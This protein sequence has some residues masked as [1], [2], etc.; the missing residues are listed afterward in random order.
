MSRDRR[1]R[2]GFKHASSMDNMNL[3]MLSMLKT[4]QERLAVMERMSTINDNLGAYIEPEEEVPLYVQKEG[5]AWQKKVHGVRATRDLGMNWVERYSHKLDEMEIV[6]TIAGKR[7]AAPKTA[8]ERE[9]NKALRSAFMKKIVRKPDLPR[10]PS[11]MEDTDFVAFDKQANGNLRSQMCCKCWLAAGPGPK[12]LDC[13]YCGAFVHASCVGEV[14]DRRF[15]F[16]SDTEHEDGNFICP[17]CEDSMNA[18][19]KHRNRTYDRNIHKYRT[20]CAV[21]KMQAGIRAAT[22]GRWFQRAVKAAKYIQRVVRARQ[23][24]KQQ[25]IVKKTEKRPVRIRIH[26]ITALVKQALPSALASVTPLAVLPQ[27]THKVGDMPIGAYENIF[28][29]AGNLSAH[30]TSNRDNFD[31][32]NLLKL[33][34]Q[35]APVY[36]DPASSAKKPKGE[37]F[38]TVSI[39]QLQDDLVGKQEY[40]IDIPLVPDSPHPSRIYMRAGRAG[41]PQ[42][43]KNGAHESLSP[44]AIN[45]ISDGYRVRDFS[46]SNNRQ[47]I[48]IP[49]STAEVVMRITVSEVTDWPKAIVKGQTEM[50]IFRNL[51]WK[52]ASSFLQDFQNPVQWQNLPTSGDGSVLSLLMPKY[53]EQPKLEL[54]PPSPAVSNGGRDMDDAE[55]KEKEGAG[56]GASPG[57]GG[58]STGVGLPGLPGLSKNA[59]GGRGSMLLGSTDAAALAKALLDGKAAEQR[60]NQELEEA[61]RVAAEEALTKAKKKDKLPQK[62]SLTALMDEA[63]GKTYPFT[64]VVGGFI[65]WSV[66]PVSENSENHYGQLISYTAAALSSGKR[67]MWFVLIDRT[68]YVYNAKSIKPKF[69]FPM[70]IV[71]VSATDGEEGMMTV[72][73]PAETLFLAAESPEQGRIWFQKLYTQSASHQRKPF[74]QLKPYPGGLNYPADAQAALGSLLAGLGTTSEERKADLLSSLSQV[75][76]LP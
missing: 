49:W 12:R 16:N 14:I 20:I 15:V 6:D 25:E 72:R 60:R 42:L 73:T 62:T 13:K 51:L 3:A 28:G 56:A 32:I 39:H 57:R 30:E 22:V 37:L 35:N 58:R 24:W 9:Q 5:S 54:L 18:E 45:A 7:V 74:S 29:V 67:R 26:D 23:F 46:V 52:K 53:D 55:E 50:S 19:A 70:S 31:M 10:R 27:E 63:Q 4:K 76:Q 33:E 17:F 66:L 48:L 1:G 44:E 47:Y 34:H 43:Q 11:D 71:S 65:S 64:S 21:I 69:Y 2:V 40:R 68:I 59:H 75:A 8:E 38:I 41:S 61:K 36:C